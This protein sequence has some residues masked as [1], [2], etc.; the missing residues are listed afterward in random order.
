MFWLIA[1]PFMERVRCGAE[2]LI[3]T[4]VWPLDCLRGIICTVFIMSAG[5]SARWNYDQFLP[6]HLPYISVV[7]FLEAFSLTHL[8]DY[9]LLSMKQVELQNFTVDFVPTKRNNISRNVADVVFS[10]FPLHRSAL[11]FRKPRRWKWAQEK[12]TNKSI[13]LRTE[14]TNE[15][16]CN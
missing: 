12:K 13:V 6:R 2:H 5:C 9:G 11:V 1:I 14:V 15:M 3:W 8:P 7:G 16:I 4:I 10:S